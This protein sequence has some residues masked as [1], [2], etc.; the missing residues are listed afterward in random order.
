[1]FNNL[2]AKN[3]DSFKNF[4]AEKL[5][6]RKVTPS[7]ESSKREK[8]TNAVDGHTEIWRYFWCSFQRGSPSLKALNCKY[9]IND[10]L[11]GNRKIKWIFISGK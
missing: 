8:S 2:V 10:S 6:T 7:P 9:I 3:F 1:M 11:K 4:I 5:V